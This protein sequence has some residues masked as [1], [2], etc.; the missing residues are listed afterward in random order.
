[1]I[2]VVVLLLL[3][4]V[5]VASWGYEAYSDARTQGRTLMAL[6]ASPVDLAQGTEPTQGDP[7]KDAAVPMRAVLSAALCQGGDACRF[8]YSRPAAPICTEPESL[9]PQ[10]LCTSVTLLGR[11]GETVRVAYDLQPTVVLAATNVVLTLVLGGIMAF[12]WGVRVR[13]LLIFKASS[14]SQI[15][16]AG[17]KDPLTGVLNRV[18][19][20]AAL[21]K[22]NQS[23]SSSG[24]VTDGCLLY[25]DLDRFKIINDTHGHIAGDL[26]LKTVTQ[27]LKYVLGDVLIGRLGGDE[28]AALLVDVS[29]RDKIETI[30]RVLIE[31]VSKPI[32]LDGVSDWVGLSIGAF[33]LKRGSLSVGELLHRA[34]TA[35]YEAKRAGRGR[36]VFYDDSMGEASKS[37][38]QV[39][40][41]L[42][43]AIE[44]KQFFMVYQPQ[45]DANEQVR[46][47]EAMVRW[48]HPARG[49]ILAEDFMPLAEQS[50]LT[51]ALGRQVIDMVCSD[52]V[53]LRR[54][55]LAL[56]YVSMDVSTRQL[57]DSAL[58]DDVQATLQRHGLSSSDIEFE[59]TESTAV[60]HSGKENATL[61]KLSALE[62]RIAIED[63]GTGYSSMSRL[64]DLKIDKLK[65][66]SVFVSTIGKPQ[67]DPALLE[68]MI[69][70]AKRLGV[71]SVAK[72]VTTAEQ[73][74]W[75]RQSG[76]TM[77]QGD[78]YA[79]PMTYA[80]LVNWFKLKDGDRDY[81][82]GVWASTQAMQEA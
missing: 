24:G 53:S 15:K 71:K 30:C 44:E 14:G 37:K 16:K 48:K 13:A 52:L 4:L 9:S 38:A 58:V 69:T 21:L 78:F 7:V 27:R 60:A 41:D 72:G 5:E 23:K 31:Q 63:F 54:Q 66:D 51:V 74:A 61:K 65:I 22:H 10:L 3:C 29:S 50:G 55:H 45:F 73:V 34:D 46:G 79:K 80:Q 36:L 20:E 25:F 1:V 47:V 70:L 11:P 75:L 19:F 81:A 32:Q 62:F 82:D 8:I 18:A 57:A 59:V 26:V 76:C 33:M 42:K 2:T 28:F 12:L 39:Q 77:M 17:E 68:L 67:F 43:N 49:V 6:T 56:P 64:L 35:M 40:A